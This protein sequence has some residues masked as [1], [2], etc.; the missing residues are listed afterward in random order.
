MTTQI[1]L[2][3]G[4]D[5]LP[6]RTQ[7]VGDVSDGSGSVDEQQ[8]ALAENRSRAQPRSHEVDDEETHLAGQLRQV[9]L[10]VVLH[11]RR[12]CV[13]VLD[14]AGSSHTVQ[15]D[16]RGEG[17]LVVEVIALQVDLVDLDCELGDV[18]QAHLQGDVGL[19]LETLLVVRKQHDLGA[20]GELLHPGRIDVSVLQATAREQQSL[21]AEASEPLLLTRLI[22]LRKIGK[23][24][25]LH[26]LREASLQDECLDVGPED[27]LVE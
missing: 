1:E 20:V 11:D 18:L 22:S 8:G 24:V 26:L 5:D 4:G 12:L 21:V 19:R 14:L 13:G 23:E 15:V 10:L 16:V 25:L 17:S 2:S 7:D 9:E 27:G 3:S 6:V